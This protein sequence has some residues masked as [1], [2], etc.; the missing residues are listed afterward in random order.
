MHF[1]GKAH[2]QQFK[3]STYKIDYACQFVLRPNYKVVINFRVLYL[4][5]FYQKSGADDDDIQIISF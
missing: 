3:Q 5:V 1:K 2:K 4:L